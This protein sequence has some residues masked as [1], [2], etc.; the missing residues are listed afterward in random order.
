MLIGR[1]LVRAPEG[2]AEVT[3]SAFP[4]DVGGYVANV[5]RWRRQIN[6]DPVSPAEVDQL[7][8]PLDLAGS[9]AMLV[10]M[11][12]QKEGRSVRLIGAIVPRSDRTW[13]YKLLGDEAVAGREKA[14]FVKFVEGAR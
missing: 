8:G 14:A 5:N 7:I 11:T 4:G 3:V 9:Q 2:H 1:F 10:D 12:G 6:L 13:F